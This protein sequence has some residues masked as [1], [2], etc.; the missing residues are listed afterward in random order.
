[1]WYSSVLYH[2]AP[3]VGTALV[4]LQNACR[5]GAHHLYSVQT[6]SPPSAAFLS[7]V[8]VTTRAWITMR[9]LGRPGRN[10]SSADSG[11][12]AK[13]R[14]RGVTRPN[15]AQLQ[16]RASCHCRSCRPNGSTLGPPQSSVQVLQASLQD[17]YHPEEFLPIH[18]SNCLFFD[19]YLFL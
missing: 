16:H 17:R 14:Q 3:V 4:V 2:Y 9:H 11:G 1:M 12:R 7:C 10:L 15:R 6:R 19:F 13:Q 5:R 8:R 18:K